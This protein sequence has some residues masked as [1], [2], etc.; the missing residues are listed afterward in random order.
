VNTIIPDGEQPVNQGRIVELSPAD[1]SWIQNESL[2][3]VV[4]LGRVS[5][6]DQVGGVSL[7]SQAAEA[8][9]FAHKHCLTYAATLRFPAVKVTDRIPGRMLVA[10]QQEVINR[11]R[12]LILTAKDRLTRQA[13][14]SIE[15]RITGTLY[16]CC[17]GP[18]GRSWNQRRCFDYRKTAPPCRQTPRK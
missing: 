9:A 8:M 13:L 2:L 17:L 10:I 6:S 11:H 7:D 12:V 16:V 4:G 5:G 1:V 14:R 15:S 18:S 3:T